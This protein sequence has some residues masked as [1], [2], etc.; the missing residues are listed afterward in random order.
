LIPIN[1]EDAAKF[2]C[3]AVVVGKTVIMNEGPKQ[4]AKDLELAGYKTEFVN[5]SEFIKSG[6]SAK[7]CTLELP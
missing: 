7:C 4:I 6:G 2:A 5:M 1:H 3:N